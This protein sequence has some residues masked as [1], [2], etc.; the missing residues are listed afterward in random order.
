MSRGFVLL[1]V[2]YLELIIL[3]AFKKGIV[4]FQVGE[5]SQAE[6]PSFVRS[7]ARRRENV[8]TALSGW[9]LMVH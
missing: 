6:D 9:F 7:A 1:D 2:G 8:S 5:S 3:Y 4:S